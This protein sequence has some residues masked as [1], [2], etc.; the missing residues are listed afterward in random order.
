MKVSLT[1][2]LLPNVTVVVPAG[3]AVVR[4]EV[5]TVLL[6][7]TVRLPG[8]PDE[9]ADTG[10]ARAPDPVTLGVNIRP[11]RPP[12]LLLHSGGQQE[13]PQGGQ[14]GGTLNLHCNR[15]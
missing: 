10:E 7:A 4:V 2:R 13:G 5:E 14:L 1:E 9:L 15:S 6:R 8:R 12:V 11:A 3:V